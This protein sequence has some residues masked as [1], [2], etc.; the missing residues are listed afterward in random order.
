MAR[1]VV[2][3][4]LSPPGLGAVWSGQ[5]GAL[6][7]Q[8]LELW[9]CIRRVLRPMQVR[10][11]YWMVVGASPSQEEAGGPGLGMSKK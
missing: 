6:A 11:N 4:I 10:E 1:Q 2:C 7:R 9:D 8:K 3:E 5:A